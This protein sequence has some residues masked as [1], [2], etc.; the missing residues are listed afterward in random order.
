MDEKRR[1]KDYAVSKSMLLA[2]VF[3]GLLV[4]AIA[5]TLFQRST[6]ILTTHPLNELLLS[7]VWSPWEGKFGFF[8]FIAGTLW[9]TGLAMILSIPPSLL[10]AIYLAEYAPSRIRGIVKPLI[11]LLA[12]IPSVVFGLWGLL[13]IVPL[14]RNYVAPLVG[15]TTTGYTVLA[16]GIVLSIMVSPIIISISEEVIRSVPQHVREASTAL[17]ATKWQTVKHVVIRSASP[18]VVAAVILGFGRAFGE[19]MAVLMVVGNVVKVPTSLF[20]PAYPLPALIANN[21]GDLMSIPS[22]DSAL[23]FAALILLFIVL[24]FS[25]A[26]ALLL[27]RIKK[28]YAIE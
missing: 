3:S 26:A 23:M 18:G 5:V 27:S 22:F 16:G 10:M 13:F 19:T 1:L 24:A 7:S 11:D 15:T 14:I 28:G 21:Y 8:P 17:G 4:F 20:D 2:T 25:V 6:L 9:V 12:G